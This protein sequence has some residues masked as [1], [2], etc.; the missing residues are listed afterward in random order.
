[1]LTNRE[2]KIWSDI[3][4]WEQQLFQY[5]PNDLEHT[6]NKW[7]E[8]GF[9]SLSEKLKAKFF[10]QLDMSMFHIHSLLNNS[11]MQADARDRLLA[12]A[13]VF[14]S[15]ISQIEDIQRLTI[16]QLHYL[17]S[18]FVT[19]HR[20]YSF[21]QGGVSGSGGL[22]AVGSDVPAMAVINIRSVQLISLSYGYDVMTPSN[23]MIAL[24]VFHAAT[25][26]IRLRAEA[27]GKLLEELH[28]KEEYFYIGSEQLTNELWLQEPL[29]QVMKGLMIQLF[30]KKEVSGIPLISMTIGA[31]TNY[32]LTRR[33]TTFAE[34][35]YQY[36]YLHD[37]KEGQYEFSRS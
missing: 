35:F 8:L 19:R 25:L 15:S 10:E 4:E 3:E 33:V 7:V 2:Q 1:M 5:E 18:Q 29:N 9:A 37:K 36:R 6:Y 31:M 17:A 21:V 14:D 30:R 11:Q 20:M 27:W 24:K 22:V 12:S 16:D 13:R 34:K 28:S 23:M 26:P 32:Q